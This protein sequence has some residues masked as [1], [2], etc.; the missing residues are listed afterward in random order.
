[1]HVELQIQTLL[2]KGLR[3]IH[4]DLEGK[5]L[6]GGAVLTSGDDEQGLEIF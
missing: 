1:M 5:M 2:V 4:I 3:E 6:D